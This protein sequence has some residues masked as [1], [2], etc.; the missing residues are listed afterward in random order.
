MCGNGIRCVGKY[1]YD[2]KMTNKEVITIETLAGIKVLEMNISKAKVQTVK[3]D[4]G[5][6]ILSP[7]KIPMDSD[8]DRFI[9][10]PIEIL[11]KIFNITGVSMGNPHAIAYIDDVDSFDLEKYG[12]AMEVHSL[13]PEK[14]NSEFVQ[15]IDR[16]TLK[17]RVWE[18]GAG[19]TLACGTGACAVVVSSI[20]N[21]LCER[22]ITVKLL[23]GDLFIEWN[24]QDNHIYM[25][26]S[27]T[28]VFTGEIDI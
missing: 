4:M 26:G 19:E 10:K 7:K 1:V 5:E 25:T 11:D 13:F 23:G 20:L 16:Q 14:V 8:L 17:M 15:V 9:N 18:R 12:S 28:T 6:P 3:V 27:A 21:N 24:E 2:N 22:K